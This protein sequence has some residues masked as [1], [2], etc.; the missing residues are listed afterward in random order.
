MEMNNNSG[1]LFKN[2]HKSLP[3]HPILKGSALVGG[4]KY[5][6]AVWKKMSKSG[7]TFYSMSFDLHKPNSEQ[8]DSQIDSQEDDF[9]DGISF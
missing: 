3:K 6:V 5:Q 9:A 1:L 4:V 7:A 8:S 2:A